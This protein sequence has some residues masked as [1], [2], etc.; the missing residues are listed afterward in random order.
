MCSAGLGFLQSGNEKLLHN[1][2]IIS[3][4]T[5]KAWRWPGRDNLQ[6]SQSTKD[7]TMA[8]IGEVFFSS[9]NEP[10]SYKTISTIIWNWSNDMAYIR[11]LKVFLNCAKGQRRFM[12]TFMQ[13]VLIS[14]YYTR[15][16]TCLHVW[17][18][19]FHK[20]VFH[21]PASSNVFPSDLHKRIFPSRT[22]LHSEFKKQSARQAGLAGSGH[23]N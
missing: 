10:K 4:R 2:I 7:R 22:S 1:L 14:I 5:F 12:T 16:N 13:F 3:C 23:R 9:S 8:Y 15:L 20:S 6:R 11:G 21:R 18:E 19:N 17:T